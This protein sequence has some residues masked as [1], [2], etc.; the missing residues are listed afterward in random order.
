MESQDQ[1]GKEQSVMS[2]YL[3]CGV[4]DVEAPTCKPINSNLERKC[5]E[6]CSQDVLILPMISLA[7]LAV[8][9]FLSPSIL[10]QLEIQA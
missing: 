6:V 4:V 8:L 10:L 7:S 3:F 2:L 5:R 1:L 9:G